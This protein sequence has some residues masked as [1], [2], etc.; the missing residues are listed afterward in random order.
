MA[1]FACTEAGP[2]MSVVLILFMLKKSQTNVAVFS[3]A[4]IFTYDAIIIFNTS[5][6]NT[7][8]GLYE[9]YVVQ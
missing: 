8:C 2:G 3:V 4:N 6:L 1:E 7:I 5:T 9:R